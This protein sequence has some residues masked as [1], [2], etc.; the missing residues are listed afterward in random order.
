LFE[1]A[2]VPP[3]YLKFDRRFVDG[4][5]AA[6]VSRRRL[7]GSLVAAARELQVSTIAEGVERPEDAEACLR[8]GFSHAQGFHFGRP[9]PFGDVERWAQRR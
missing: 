9:G 1:L 3:H 2:E 8:V 6:P 4:L 5:H 7:V